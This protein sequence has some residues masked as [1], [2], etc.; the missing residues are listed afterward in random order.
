MGL[1]QEVLVIYFFLRLLLLS[2]SFRT[3]ALYLLPKLTENKF[4]LLAP[5]RLIF[6]F[7]LSTTLCLFSVLS[8]NTNSNYKQLAKTL[9]K[10]KRKDL[11]FSMHFKLLLFTLIKNKKQIGK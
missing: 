8:D 2:L 7:S 1:T 3:S 4:Y 9:G 10:N 5:T 11:F 6:T